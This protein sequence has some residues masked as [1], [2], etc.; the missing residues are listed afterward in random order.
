MS[1]KKMG[2]SLTQGT[3]LQ[4]RYVIEK[5]IG[6]GGFG[7]TYRAT[8]TRVDVPVAVKEYLTERN[9]S[10]KEA[11]QETKMAAKFYALEGIAAARD[12]FAESGHVYI[13]ME[14]VTGV[15]IKKYIREHGPMNG[16]E[17]L[18]KIRPIMEALEKIH[19]EG[20]IHRDI[21]ADNLMITR[22]GKLKLVDF[23]TARFTN[24]YLNK[25]HTLVFKRGFAP[26]EQCRTNGRQGP[27]TDIYA[28]CAT[29]YYM[30]TGIVPDDAVERMID[31]RLK[32]LE[33]MQGTRL[34]VKKRACIM[35]GLEVDPEK[36]Y[37][38]IGEFYT[39]LYET[40]HLPF[41]AEEQ[42]TTEKVLQTGYSTTALLNEIQEYE[43]E[44]QTDVRN[45]KWVFAISGAVLFLFVAGFIIYNQGRTQEMLSTAPDPVS[46]PAPTEEITTP[47][48]SPEEKTVYNIEDYT[49]LTKKQVLT[50]TKTL[51][52]AGLTISFKK[53]YSAKVKAGRIISQKPSAGKEY[54]RLEDVA[55]VLTISR[56]KKATPTPLATPVVTPAPEP[57]SGKKDKVDF[58]GD[59]DSIL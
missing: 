18:Q 7:T 19:Q 26:I 30:V 4:E 53:Q 1:D 50:K 48:P 13:V 41:A 25:P 42:L 37:Q 52:K 14:Y 58:Q 45:R 46:T 43:K 38:T 54:E 57:S 9:F 15:S 34:H 20:V 10:E 2:A 29:M 55:L 49:G 23:G 21:S 22:E 51:R 59:L 11:L 6:R 8:D 31:D 56:G 12:F 39:E 32:S 27:W 28:L 24:E 3:I 36:R 33:Q 44:K 17:M 47:S 35:K 40:D 5:V 16:E